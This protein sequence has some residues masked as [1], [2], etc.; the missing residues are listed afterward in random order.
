MTS[1]LAIALARWQLGSIRG[2]ELPEAAT[3][4]LE[5]GADSPNLRTL[6]GLKDPT[7]D[8]AVPYLRRA[9]EELGLP[10]PTKRAAGFT[11]ARDLCRRIVAGE[12]T[13]HEGA[14][15]IWW[16]VYNE[17]D[18][19]DELG[20]F[21][22]TASQ[23]DDFIAQRSSDPIQYDELIAQCEQDIRDAASQFLDNV[24]A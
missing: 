15:L 16:Q 20:V 18:Y 22:G 23:L 19:P 2:D 10:A 24:A 5:A 11:I 9:A 21:A 8:E 1:P 17:I 7:L 4:A 13:P 3:A 12:L 6:A 14:R